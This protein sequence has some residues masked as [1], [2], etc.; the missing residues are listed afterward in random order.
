MVYSYILALSRTYQDFRYLAKLS[1][2]THA[3]ICQ[4]P[5]QK[6]TRG[7]EARGRRS[8]R[9]WCAETGQEFSPQR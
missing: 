5:S 1:F 6:Y 3:Q 2:Q 8:H 9:N 7:L 4:I